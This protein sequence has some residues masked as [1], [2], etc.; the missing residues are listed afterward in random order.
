MGIGQ[1]CPGGEGNDR[2]H[3]LS[4]WVVP[5]DKWLY[6]SRCSTVAGHLIDPLQIGIPK[7]GPAPGK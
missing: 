1:N 6:S 2:P 7:Y 4:T 3:H 5:W